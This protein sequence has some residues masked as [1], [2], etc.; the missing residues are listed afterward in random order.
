MT[1]HISPS[2]RYSSPSVRGSP[3]PWRFPSPFRPLRY[4]CPSRYSAESA[5]PRRYSE[6]YR[7][8]H[9]RFYSNC[10]YHVD[11]GEYARKKALGPGIVDGTRNGCVLCSGHGMVYVCIY[12]GNRFCRTD[13][14][15][16]LVCHSFHHPR[17][18]Q[19]RVGTHTQQ[20]PAQ[21][22]R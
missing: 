8:L 11:D 17:C 7:R 14:G 4:F 5:V 10:S 2:L 15:T 16:R 12:E 3:S 21:A 13:N 9:H 1:W 20:H 19:D 22:S 18:G 6:Y